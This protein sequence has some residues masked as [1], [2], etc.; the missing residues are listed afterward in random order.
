M[1]ATKVITT[2]IES[3]SYEAKERCFEISL[4]NGS[5]LL[6]PVDLLVMELMG[7]RAIKSS[8]KAD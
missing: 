7:R 8:T 2:L 5:R 4:D 6:V 1:L 3:V